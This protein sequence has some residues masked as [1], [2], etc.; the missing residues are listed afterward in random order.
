M[1]RDKD[2]CFCVFTP[3]LRRDGFWSGRGGV[4]AVR[5]RTGGR[6][7]CRVS[8]GRPQQAVG[9]SAEDYGSGVCKTHE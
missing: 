1:Q 3:D 5:Q 4:G 6:D 7:A 8:V 2:S 9:R